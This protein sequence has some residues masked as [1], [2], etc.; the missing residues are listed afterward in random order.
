M[1]LLFLDCLPFKS[2]QCENKEFSETHSENT[3][4]LHLKRLHT[5]TTWLLREMAHLLLFYS[6]TLTKTCK[7][8]FMRLPLRLFW[9]LDDDSFHGEEEGEGGR[10]ND[11]PSIPACSFIHA[12]FSFI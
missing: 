8:T 1:T 12:H 5:P 9:Q 3:S 2:E 6:V 4:V 7:A 10:E 11:T